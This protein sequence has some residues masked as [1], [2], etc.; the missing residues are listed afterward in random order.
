MRLPNL[1]IIIT[2][3]QYGYIRRATAENILE[4]KTTSA[5]ALLKLMVSKNLIFQE[6]NN[7]NIKYRIK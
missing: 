2:G 5:Y 3:T 6:G 7:K 1:K 4:D